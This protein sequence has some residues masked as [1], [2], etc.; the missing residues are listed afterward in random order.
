MCLCVR[1]D[2]EDW[3]WGITGKGGQVKKVGVSKSRK[4]VKGVVRNE[5]ETTGGRE[6][7]RGRRGRRKEG[8]EGRVSEIEGVEG[9]LVL[10]ERR[11]RERGG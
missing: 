2:E 7:E 3:R 8:G 6:G 9:G 5:G 1:W 4:R 10:W 11:G